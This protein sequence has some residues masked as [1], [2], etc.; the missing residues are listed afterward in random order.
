MLAGIIAGMLCNGLSPIGA[1]SIGAYVHGK[2][3]DLAADK[4]GDYSCLAR[5]II[6]NISSIMKNAGGKE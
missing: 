3:G 1:A 2:S 5:D 6:D 4:F